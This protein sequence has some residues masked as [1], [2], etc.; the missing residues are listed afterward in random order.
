[1]SGT[2][3]DFSP[4][5]DVRIAVLFLTRIPTGWI[6]DM[7]SSDLAGAAWAFPIVGL[8]VGAISGGVLYLLASTEL[9]PLVCAFIALGVQAFVTGALHED[10]L[11][12][13]ADGLGAGDK[14]RTLE[15]MRDSRIG[16]YGVLALILSVA[17]R[18]GAISGIAGPG[19]ACL[20]M[21]AAAIFSRGALP[22]IMHSLPTARDDGL[23]KDAGKPSLQSAA[24]A[25]AISVIALFTIMPFSVALAALV[26][27][28]VL[29]GLLLRWAMQGIGGQTGDVLGAAQQLA[30]IAVLI[31][32]AGWGFGV[33]G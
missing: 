28:S 7:R 23:S 1:M 4:L 12:D 14:A 10:G 22:V 9:S 30:E 32:A 15:I 18:A 2:P 17:I 27:G 31:A 21:I 8:I 29:V 5:Q 19:F 11:A 16:T 3:K 24:I 13:V 25:G 20:A 26:I 6:E 33:Y